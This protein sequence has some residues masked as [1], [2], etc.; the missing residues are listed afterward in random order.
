[1]EHSR[2]ECTRVPGT[3]DD[4]GFDALNW[5]LGTTNRSSSGRFDQSTFKSSHE[6]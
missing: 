6:L 4:R 3:H 5:N 1:M 2:K